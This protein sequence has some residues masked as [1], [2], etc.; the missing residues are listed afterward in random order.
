M[1]EGEEGGP[2]WELIGLW[3]LMDWSE[4]G[5]KSIEEY[6]GDGNASWAKKK[7]TRD[8]KGERSPF[9]LVP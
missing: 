1:R 6:V 4:R 3:V 5:E 9:G 8:W 7:P 2:V